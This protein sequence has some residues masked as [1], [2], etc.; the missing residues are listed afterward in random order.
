M[1]RENQPGVR[2]RAAVAA[3]GPFDVG[4]SASFA[5]QG[6][7]VHL[8]AV[9]VTLGFATYVEHGEARPSAPAAEV[10]T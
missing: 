1:L 9:L 4:D 5:S 8:G 3:A 7:S 2:L 6:L 10:Q